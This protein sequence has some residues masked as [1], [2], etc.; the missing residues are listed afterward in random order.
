MSGSP[1]S[2]DEAY[3]NIATNVILPFDFRRTKLVLGT[4]EYIAAEVVVAKIVRKVMKADNKGF[5]QLAY[6]HAL[7]MP[8]LGGA[9][10]FFEKNA[11]YEGKDDKG[12]EISFATQL[13]DGAKG[14][15]AVLIA[16]YVIDSF[17][18]GFHAPW[19]NMK[20]LLITA[21]S[22][23]LTRPLIGFLYKYLPKDAQT[24]LQVVDIMVQ[25]QQEFSTL[26]SKK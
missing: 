21:G 17:A 11:A 23:A 6:V 8:F 10:G 18:K 20:D 2:S 13:M 12:K 5:L 26:N 7:S 16:Q 19:F 1:T 25:R 4:L 15:P 24:N 9:G 14:I 22:K 3:T